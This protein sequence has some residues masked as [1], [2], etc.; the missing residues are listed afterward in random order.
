MLFEID[1]LIEC[2][3]KNRLKKTHRF[4]PV[5]VMMMMMMILKEKYMTQNC[6]S[7]M[8]LDVNYKRV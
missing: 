4:L 5:V 2:N 8:V 3:E 7:V 1:N 6:Y